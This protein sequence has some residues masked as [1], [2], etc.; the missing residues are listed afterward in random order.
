MDIARRVSI[1]RWGVSILLVL[2]TMLGVEGVYLIHQGFTGGY[3]WLAMAA[4]LGFAPWAVPR[5]LARRFLSRKPPESETTF[6]FQEEGV[7]ITG[8]IGKAQLKWRAFSKFEETERMFF[9]YLRSG[10]FNSVPKRVMSAEQ[11]TELR[12]ILELRIA[13]DPR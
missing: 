7:G 5:Y 3:F 11:I 10:R 2:L 1:P 12:K 9:L 13:T 4:L 6:L 8:S